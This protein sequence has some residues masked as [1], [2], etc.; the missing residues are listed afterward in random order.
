MVPQ[1]E[2][3]EVARRRIVRAGVTLLGNVGFGMVDIIAEA[4]VS[5]GACY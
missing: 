2:R 3:A 5:K 1:Q 4:G